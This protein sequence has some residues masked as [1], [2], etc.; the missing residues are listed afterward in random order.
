MPE[1]PEKKEKK[2]TKWA[3]FCLDYASAITVHFALS[4]ANLLEPECRVESLLQIPADCHFF[5]YVTTR[6]EEGKTK[7][8]DEIRA[9]RE[10]Y[11]F[12]PEPTVSQ[13][14]EDQTWETVPHK[15]GGIEFDIV[16]KPASVKDKKK[17]CDKNFYSVL[18]LFAF[19]TRTTSR[20]YL[21]PDLVSALSGVFSINWHRTT[22]CDKDFYSVLLLFTFAT[23]CDGHRTVWRPRYKPASV[24][25]KKKRCDKNFCS[26]LLLFAFATRTTSR[27]C[28]DGHRTVWRPRYKPASVKDKKKRCDKNF[29][30]VLLLFAFATRTTS[31]DCRDGHR[32][33]WRPRY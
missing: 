3:K 18:L 13:K 1:R 8:D 4:L 25:D 27:D 15:F 24:K 20:D 17:R 14:E 10:Y 5:Y 26:V 29:C 2:N 32:T 31:R 19:A 22:S 12:V 30:S 9:R 11:N 16:Q 21:P 33:V 7:P 28:R 23:S 6:L